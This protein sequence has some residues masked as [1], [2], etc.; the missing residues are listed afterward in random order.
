VATLRAE[1]D[2]K[3][4]TAAPPPP[5]VVLDPKTQERLRALGYVIGPE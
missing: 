3:G 2:D 4:T 1:L 5:R